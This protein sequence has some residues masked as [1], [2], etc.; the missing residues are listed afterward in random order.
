[1]TGNGAGPIA[2]AHL[3]TFRSARAAARSLARDRGRLAGV[4]GLRFAR[5][6]FVGSR[7]SDSM[8]LGWVDP[9]RQMAM[10]IWEDESALERFRESP[11]GRAWQLDTE[12]R[13]E[14]RLTPFRAHGSYRGEQPL[15]GLPSGS[16][17]AGPVALMTFAN[18]PARGLAYF[19]RGIN[20]STRELH[21]SPGLIAAA[22]GPERWYRGGMTFTIW[23]SLPAALG[24][25]YR[26]DP[27]RGIVKSVREH[28]RLIDSMF[29]R[30]RPYAAE[31]T[32]FPWSRFAR[33]FG[34]F[35]GSTG[36]APAPG[37]AGASPPAPAA[38]S[39]RA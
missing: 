4:P 26:R 2:S 15:A 9:R 8:D 22:A 35:V 3:F 24:F 38:R 21:A 6:V 13:C 25:S 32:W 12:Q 17:V 18:I 1:M 23:E 11:I 30:L 36:S 20:R 10:C 16:D 19:W 14:V 31:G 5:V 29:I 34:E 33:P 39:P 27:H 7:R 28:G 37:P